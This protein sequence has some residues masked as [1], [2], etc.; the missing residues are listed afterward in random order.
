M[1]NRVSHV[2]KEGS[3]GAIREHRVRYTFGPMLDI[4]TAGCLSA[5]VS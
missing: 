1:F 4:R 5:G 3:S 2:F